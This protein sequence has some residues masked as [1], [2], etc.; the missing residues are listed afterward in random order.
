MGDLDDI[1]KKIMQKKRKEKC[2]EKRQPQ[3]QKVIRNKPGTKNPEAFIAA[4]RPL[5]SKEN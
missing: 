5:C 2:S 1:L 3:M 4:T